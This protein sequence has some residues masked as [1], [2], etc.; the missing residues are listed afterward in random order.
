MGGAS[1]ELDKNWRAVPTK[2]IWKDIFSD[3]DIAAL[4]INIT[5]THDIPHTRFRAVMGARVS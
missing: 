2:S 1:R 4:L 5:E 3:V